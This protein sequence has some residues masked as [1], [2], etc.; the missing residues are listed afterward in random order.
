[1]LPPR[2]RPLAVT[3]DVTLAP[4]AVRRDVARE[5]ARLLSSGFL[6]DGRPALFNPA[7]LA[8]ATPLYASPVIAAVHAVAGVTAVRLTRFGFID[9]PAGAAGPSPELRFGTLELA[10]LDNDPVHPDRGYALV[11]LEGGR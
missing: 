10:R 7:N 3:L 4:A 9:Q 11:S 1:M 8:F 6:P 2:Y 5:L